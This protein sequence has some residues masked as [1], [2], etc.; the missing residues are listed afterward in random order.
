[1]LGWLE[2][3]GEKFWVGRGWRSRWFSNLGI[4]IYVGEKRVSYNMSKLV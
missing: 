1:M 2:G 4:F 3:Y